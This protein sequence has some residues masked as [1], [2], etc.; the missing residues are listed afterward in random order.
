MKSDLNDVERV[1]TLLL[2]SKNK[3]DIK[4]GKYVAR[5]TSLIIKGP[6]FDITIRQRRAYEWIITRTAF[7]AMDACD[8][9]YWNGLKWEIKERCSCRDM[10]K[11][12]L[13]KDLELVLQDIFNYES[14]RER[15]Q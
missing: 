2:P 15:K 5:P 6:G 14:K 12:Y 7:V 3:M 8:V 11:G 10:G 4:I 13:W 1:W 9:V